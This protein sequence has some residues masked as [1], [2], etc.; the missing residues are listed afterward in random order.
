M[1]VV[2]LVRFGSIA[3]ERPEVGVVYAQLLADGL[4][5]RPAARSADELCVLVG[6]KSKLTLYRALDTLNEWGLLAKGG[7][8][9]APKYLIGLAPNWSFCKEVVLRM[10]GQET[11]DDVQAGNMRAELSPTAGPGD[12]VVEF[13]LSALHDRF[14]RHQFF[15][16]TMPSPS[17]D[18]GTGY[19]SFAYGLRPG[20]HV[21]WLGEVLGNQTD[22]YTSSTISAE[23]ADFWG[24]VYI[25][26]VNKES[27]SVVRVT[28]GQET[29]YLQDIHILC[30]H[31]VYPTVVP[32]GFVAP[33]VTTRAER[34][35]K[36]RQSNL[37]PTSRGF[38][39]WT[40]DALRKDEEYYPIVERLVEYSN[41]LFRREEVVNW[42]LYI[43]VRG[44]LVEEKCSEETI[45]RALKAA[46]IDPFWKDKASVGKLC[47]DPNRIRDLSRKSGHDPYVRSTAALPQLRGEAG[48]AIAF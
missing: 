13:A 5:G 48:D 7:S 3:I 44:C 25:Q 15:P 20:K 22:L 1:S 34:A 33:T 42:Q 18:A 29:L 40:K 24:K 23:T 16:L 27:V 43:D 30:N 32:M 8:R 37:P 2:E 4:T 6:V 36:A 21:E 9:R 41:R 35:A 39:Y 11:L 19:V 12:P 47:K 38:V 26:A 10:F 46:S 17:E 31:S 14:T 45:C 28:A